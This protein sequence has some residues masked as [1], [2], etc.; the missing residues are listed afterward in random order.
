MAAQELVP[1]SEY[2][3]YPLMTQAEFD[4]ACHHFHNRYIQATLGPLRRT[5]R[6]D[7]RHDMFRDSTYLE[8]IQPINALQDDISDL[9]NFGALR[10]SDIDDN[11]IGGNN[12]VGMDFDAEDADTV[13]NTPLFLWCDRF[14]ELIIV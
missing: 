11:E 9:L 3:N 4:L 8:I 7:V 12:M 1:F 14:R 10:A 13:I 5:F 6:V 2:Q